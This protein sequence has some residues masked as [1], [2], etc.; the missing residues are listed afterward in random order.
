MRLTHSTVG[1][2]FLFQDQD[3]NEHIAEMDAVSVLFINQYTLA[4]TGGPVRF[5]SWYDNIFD[6]YSII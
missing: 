2:N 3:T 4:A 6:M 5:G 1:C